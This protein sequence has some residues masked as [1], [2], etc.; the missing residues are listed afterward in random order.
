MSFCKLYV[1]YFLERVADIF[2]SLHIV[3][4]HG[5]FAVKHFMAC[6]YVEASDIDAQFLRHQ[7]R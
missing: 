5:Y 6:R 4:L 7:G 3:Y 2:H 1:F